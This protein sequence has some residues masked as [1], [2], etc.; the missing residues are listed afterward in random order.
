MEKY[1]SRAE[2]INKVIE[3]GKNNIPLPEDPL[4][5]NYSSFR[6]ADAEGTDFL[7]IPEEIRTWPYIVPGLEQF[8]Q[9]EHIIFE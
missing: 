2:Y 3:D 7:S 5:G 4:E 1:L 6:G 8:L 9:N